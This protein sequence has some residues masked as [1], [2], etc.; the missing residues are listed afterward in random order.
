MAINF[1]FDTNRLFMCTFAVPGT[2]FG[3]NEG[4]RLAK[5]HS[6]LGI[7]F[8]ESHIRNNETKTIWK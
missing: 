5:K 2:R 8:I 7:K 4:K 6:I 1:D 3:F